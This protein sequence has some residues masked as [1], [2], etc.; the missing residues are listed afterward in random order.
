[1]SRIMSDAEKDFILAR[2]LESIGEK[3]S[4][5]AISD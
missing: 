2:E 1:M 5:L 4:P 3:T